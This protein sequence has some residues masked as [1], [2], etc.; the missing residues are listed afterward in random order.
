MKTLLASVAIASTIGFASAASYNTTVIANASVGLITE[1]VSDTLSNGNI[2]VYSSTVDLAPA[3]LAGIE[4]SGDYVAFFEAAI[5][6]TPGL[7][8]GPVAY[9][10][11]AVTSFGPAEMGNPGNF[12]YLLIDGG[13]WVGVYQGQS[14]PGVGAITFNPSLITEDLVGTSTP[15]VVGAT[16]SGFQLVTGIPEPSITLLG[17][18]GVLG[19]LRRRR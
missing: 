5:T 3:D 9:V 2:Y 11:G 19:L 10:A 17:A 1:G 4:T 6:A 18:L 8:R 14:T 15:T 13:D 7:A 12:N 16:N